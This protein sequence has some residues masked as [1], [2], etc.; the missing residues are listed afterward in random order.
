MS[1]ESVCQAVN[2]LFISS[3]LQN[4]NLLKSAIVINNYQQLMNVRMVVVQSS[5]QLG[6]AMVHLVKL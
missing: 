2:N 3:G 5:Q 6:L 4:L 1:G